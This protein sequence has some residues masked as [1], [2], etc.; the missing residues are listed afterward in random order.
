[1]ELTKQLSD[2]LLFVHNKTNAKE[3]LEFINGHNGVVYSAINE[4]LATTVE[5]TERNCKKIN[6]IAYPLRIMIVHG[7]IYKYKAKMTGWTMYGDVKLYRITDKGK[8]VL[9]ILE[10]FEVTPTTK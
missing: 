8:E 1:V 2:L 3:I 9:K 10:M 7:F 4:H 6:A 5:D